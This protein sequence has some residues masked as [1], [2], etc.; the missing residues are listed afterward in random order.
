MAL[1][2]GL[3]GALFSQAPLGPRPE[4]YLGLMLAIGL[5]ASWLGTLC[6]N[7]ASALLP[8]SLAGQLIVFETLAALAYGFMHRGVMPEPTAWVGIALLLA[9]V[10]AGSRAFAAAR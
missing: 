1:Y 6:W 5:L 8:T 9:G 7:R 4:A 2:L 3:S 10:L